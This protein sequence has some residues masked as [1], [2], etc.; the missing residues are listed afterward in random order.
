MRRQ[1][2]IQ[3]RP[4]GTSSYH[5]TH[6]VPSEKGCMKFAITWS[7]LTRN[8]GISNIMKNKALGYIKRRY[9][10][11]YL[12]VSP[13]ESFFERYD[14]I[15]LKKEYYS[16]IVVP[17]VWNAAEH[18]IS[19]RF[20]FRQVHVTDWRQQVKGVEYDDTILIDLNRED[21]IESKL[22]WYIFK[23]T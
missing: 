1:Q 12:D 9:N 13:F 20:G 2:T 5:R 8:M 3:S 14:D 17:F 18:D 7:L 16:P 10:I 4:H 21:D 6:V 22:D 15:V 23:N 11:E 19:R